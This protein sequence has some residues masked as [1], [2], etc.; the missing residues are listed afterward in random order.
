MEWS[1]KKKEEFRSLLPDMMLLLVC[2][3]CLFVCL[4]VCFVVGI[5]TWWYFVLL[6]K[7]RGHIAFVVPNK[8]VV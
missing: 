5:H 3:F 1:F 6:L 8:K 4:F 2:L 7:K